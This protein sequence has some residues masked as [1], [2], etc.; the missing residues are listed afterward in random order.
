MFILASGINIAIN[1]KKQK[2]KN[3]IRLVNLTKKLASCQK[4]KKKASYTTSHFNN[5]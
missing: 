1:S 4:E 5:A 2:N 3:P